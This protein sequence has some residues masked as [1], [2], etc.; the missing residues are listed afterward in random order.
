MRVL[1]VNKFL[2]RRGGAEGYMIDLAAMQQQ[3]G[4]HVE[5][6]G[7]SHPDNVPLHYASEFPSHVEFEPAPPSLPGRVQVLGR[8]MWSTSA[9]RGISHVIDDFA[10]DVAHLH[11][12]YHQ[13]SPSI[14]RA[15]GRAGVPVVMT[16]HDYKLACP[17]YQFRAQ[18]QLCTAC[19]SGGPVQAARRRCKDGALLPSAI[20][21]TEVA[22]HRRFGAYDPVD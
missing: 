21:A 4:D 3:A 11:N 14:L 19:V 13:L 9:A 1:H 16:L 20:A 8:M 18:G 6:Y 10:P 5:F 12:I 15:L 7:M 2:Y 22:V 17:T